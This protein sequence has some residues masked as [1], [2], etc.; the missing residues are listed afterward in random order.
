MYKVYVGSTNKVKVAAVK[1]AL[2]DY[3]V[4]AIEVGSQVHKQPWGDE[5]TIKGAYNR[6]LALPKGGIRIGL[7]A[8]VSLCEGKLFLINWGVLIDEKDDVYYAGGTRIPLPDLVKEK[9]MDRKYELAE[10]MD[11]YYH[12]TDIK[13]N[14]GAISIFT[15]GLVKRKD[16]FTHIVKLLYGQYLYR[17]KQNESFSNLN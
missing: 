15:D 17:R 1:E 9:L 7:E 6:A 2:S 13:H 3:E 12:T 14:E 8:G 11:K 10:V 5:E 16:I 4:I